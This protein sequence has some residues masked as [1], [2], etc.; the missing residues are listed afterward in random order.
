MT[1]LY[2]R[3]ICT[4]ANTNLTFYDTMEYC[5]THYAQIKPLFEAMQEQYGKCISK[6]YTYDTNNKNKV[7]F[8]NGWIFQKKTKHKT[9]KNSKESVFMQETKVIISMTRPERQ[10]SFINYNSPFDVYTAR[11]LTTNQLSLF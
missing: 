5:E 8:H 3:I 11:R 7:K 10:I 2:A 9:A 1:S 6:V 4:N